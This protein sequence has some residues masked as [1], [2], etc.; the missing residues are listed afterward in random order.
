MPCVFSFNSEIRVNGHTLF[1]RFLLFG[2]YKIILLCVHHL[3]H[4]VGKKSER[5]CRQDYC[6]LSGSELYQRC[7]EFCM[8]KFY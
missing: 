3:A 5:Y 8:L 4:K 6:T 7:M 1:L 2:S